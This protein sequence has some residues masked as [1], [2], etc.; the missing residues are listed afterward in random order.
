MQDIWDITV[1][2]HANY[3]AGG[4]IHANSG[5]TNGGAVET[6]RI[7]C[8]CDPYDKA[9]KKDGKALIVGLDGDHLAMMWAKCAHPGAFSMIRDEHTKLWRAVRVDPE[10]PLHLD[11]Y[12]EAYREKWKD[13]PPFFPAR[14]IRNIAW[15]EK[16]KG[17]PRRVTF[18]NGWNSLW[19]SS[20]GDSPQ[21]D[22]L[23]WVWIDEQI[24]NEDFFEEGRRGIVTTKETRRHKPRMIWTA[25]PQNLNPQLSDL[26]E[27]ADQG[28]RHVAAFKL[29]I[30]DNPYIPDEAKQAFFDGLSEDEREVRWYGIPAIAR[31]RVYPGYNPQGIHGYDPFEIDISC[32]A[33]YVAVDPGRQHCGTVFFAVDPEQEHVWVYDAFDLRN[34]DAQ[35][36]AG[37]VARRQHDMQFEAFVIDQQMGKQHTPGSGINVAQ[38]Y[39][40]AMEA[41]G[42]TPTTTGPLNGFFPGTNDVSAREESVISWLTVRGVGPFAGSPA[43]QVQRGLSPQLDKQFRDAVYKAGK[44]HKAP[45]QDILVCV[46]YMAGY[47]P[48]YKEP[49][50]IVTPG[51]KVTLSVHD[52]FKAKQKRHRDRGR[53][54]AL[55]PL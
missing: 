22:H 13:A 49:T 34:S 7:L 33:R 5:K 55:A 20:K 29:L 31:Q 21:G 17:I 48:K 39:Y 43:L 24:E 36:W 41:A 51:V 53:R 27:A 12:D 54:R 42:V 23:N 19:R 28:K 52:Q 14:M 1:D 11:P 35:G 32:W 37:E 46:E 2:K 50:P 9:P 18:Q 30:V 40:S 25:T 15:E 8:G 47:A 44:R 16:R 4:L 38:Q 3:S 6:A 26:R 45:A 10:D